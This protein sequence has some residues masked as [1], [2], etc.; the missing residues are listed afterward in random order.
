MTTEWSKMDVKEFQENGL[1]AQANE[2]FFWPL[3]LALTVTKLEDGTYSPDLFIQR[4][5]PYGVIYAG[6]EP[7]EREARAGRVEAW[8]KARMAP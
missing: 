2:Q 5:D 1:L 3:G 6:D 4:V 8:L 7:G